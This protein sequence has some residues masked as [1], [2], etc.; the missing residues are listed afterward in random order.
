MFAH[1]P[2]ELGTPRPGNFTWRAREPTCDGE[3]MDGV[4]A[5]GVDDGEGAYDGEGVLVDG[6]AVDDGEYDEGGEDEQG[7]EQADEEQADEEAD[8]GS[9]EVTEADVFDEGEE[10]S[11]LSGVAPETSQ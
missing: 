10:S 2:S 1:D 4:E 11:F 6:E 3:G 5:E 9:R 8:M 7:M